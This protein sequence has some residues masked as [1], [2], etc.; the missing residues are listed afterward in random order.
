MPSSRTPPTQVIV[1]ATAASPADLLAGAHRST[2]DALA[3]LQAWV[4]HPQLATC[5]LVWVT[6]GAVAAADG[7][8]RRGPRPRAH[9]GPRPQRAPRVPTTPAPAR[10]HRSD[11]H[12]RGRSAPRSPCAANRSSRCAVMPYA[13]RGSR[14]RRR[15]PR[16]VWTTDGTVLVTGAHGRARRARRAPPRDSTTACATCFLSS[17]RGADARGRA[18]A[19]GRARRARRDRH[20]CRVRHRAIAAALARHAR[21]ASRATRRCARC[22]IAPAPSTTVRSPR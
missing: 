1:D 5:E 21:G 20:A 10:R 7:D 13:R 9:L 22:S 8:A 4:T 6:Q 12:A 3:L 18:R 16:D 11:E 2:H 17:R 14:S 15:C 19:T